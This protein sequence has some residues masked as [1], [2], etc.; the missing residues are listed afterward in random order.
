MSKNRKRNPRNPIKNALVDIAVLTA[1]VIEPSVFRKCMESVYREAKS[2]ASDVYVFHNGSVPETRKEYDEIM[3]GAKVLRNNQNVGF[4]AGA[5]RAIRAGF[6]PLVLFISDDIILHEGT[7]EKLVRRMD[8]PEI[9]LCG[10]KLTFPDDSQDPSRPAGRVQHIGHAINVRGDVIHPL[11][12]WSK[13]NPKCNIS[14][15]VQTVTG[16]VFLV[17][18][19][20]F[21]KTGGFF[22]GYGKGYFED[23]DMN[24]TIRS[25]GYKVFIDTECTATHYVG[26]TFIKNNQPTN[27]EYNRAILL[28]RKGRQL[29][30]DAFTF[31]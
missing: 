13:E 5:N 30:N 31:W 24:L 4:P 12:G 16:A 28:Q 25:L 23:V 18:R 15:E 9:G 14:R 1:G 20:V 3:V 11:I 21:Q 19:S 26:A 7:L 17:R 2:V 29:F 27:M 10:L 22:E 6:S 8:D